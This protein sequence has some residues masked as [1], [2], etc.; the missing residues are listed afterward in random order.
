MDEQA[1]KSYLRHLRKLEKKLKKM[2]GVDFKVGSK[3]A[4]VGLGLIFG[5]APFLPVVLVAGEII[6]IIGVIAIVL[7]R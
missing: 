4:W 2:K 3:I 5:V 6:L 7:D 1:R